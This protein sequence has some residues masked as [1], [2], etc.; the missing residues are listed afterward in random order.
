ML[1]DLLRAELGER[2]TL[3]LPFGSPVHGACLHDASIPGDTNARRA[4]LAANGGEHERADQTCSPGR[5]ES[6]AESTARR[7]FDA[8]PRRLPSDP[9]VTP[10]LD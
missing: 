6:K 5:R 2:V 4:Q 3:R 7:T 10:L 9:S 8:L 1:S